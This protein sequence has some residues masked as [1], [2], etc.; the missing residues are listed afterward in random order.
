MEPFSFILLGLVGLG[1]NLK[2]FWRRARGWLVAAIDWLNSING[3]LTAAATLLLALIAW[4]TDTT[5]RNTLIAANRAWVTPASAFLDNAPTIGKSWGYHVR[6]GNVGKEPAIGFAAQEDL[7]IIDAPAPQASLYTVLPKNSLK[8]VCAR[9]HAA[10]EGNV[11]YPSGLRDYT[12][13]VFTDRLI[14]PD[15]QGGSKVLVAHGCFAYQT[16]QRERQ[17][18]Y[19]F[20]FLNTVH[21][22]L[23][24]ADCPFGN[25]AD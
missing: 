9:T 17:S 23:E 18:E 20:I 25:T 4:N 5:L 8:D 10:T 7:D 1:M 15:I 11:V 24:G 13:S 19:C 21:G 2:S 22:D 3:L 6:Y 16:F 14:T 12:Y